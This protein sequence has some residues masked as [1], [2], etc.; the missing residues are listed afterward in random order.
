MV[1]RFRNKGFY[2]TIS[3][4]KNNYELKGMAEMR[5]LESR[6]TAIIKSALYDYLT[7]MRI[8]N[9]YRVMSRKMKSFLMGNK[10]LEQQFVMKLRYYFKWAENLETPLDKIDVGGERRLAD[11]ADREWELMTWNT[12]P[13]L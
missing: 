9:N 4:F 2:Q 13:L 10:F 1:Y 11:H 12:H 7:Q 6:N 8:F 5:V 3:G